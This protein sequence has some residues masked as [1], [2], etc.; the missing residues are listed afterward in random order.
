MQRLI[1]AALVLLAMPIAHGHAE[2]AKEDPDKLFADGNWAEAYD[3]YRDGLHDGGL[4]DSTAAGYVPKA[5]QCL[6]K[7]NRLAEWDAMIKQA[8]EANATK[9]RTLGAAAAAYYSVDHHGRLTDGEFVRGQPR[10]GGWQ[11]MVTADRRDRVRALQLY[12]QSLDVAEAAGDGD[13]AARFL[14][15]MADALQR[16]AASGRYAWRLQLLTDLSKD[17]PLPDTDPGWSPNYGAGSS[18]PV[19]AAGNPLLHNEPASWDDAKTDGERWRWLLAAAVRRDGRLKAEV[20]DRRADFA[21]NQFGVRTLAGLL[22]RLSGAKDDADAGVFAL[23]TLTDNECL[24]RL[25]T[26]VKRFELPAEHHPVRLRQEL[27]AVAIEADDKSAARGA[28]SKLADTMLNRR[29]FKRAAGYFRQSLELTGNEKQR[30][31]IEQRIAQIEGAWGEFQSAP[32]QPAGRGATIDY[33]YRNS[34]AVE[35]VAAPIDI[36]KLLADVKAYLK[37][38]PKQLNR[39]KIEIENLGRRLLYYDR[40]KYVGEPAA[41]WSVKLDPPEDHSDGQLAITTPLQKP[42]AYFV[43]ATPKLADGTP[44]VRH[45]CVLWVADTVLLR[46]PMSGAA[47]FFAADAVTGQPVG[48]ANIELFSYRQV[49]SNEN[50]R[51]YDLSTSSQAIK[52]DAAGLAVLSL[53]DPDEE[54][55]R[56]W[57]AI[58]RDETGRLAYLGFDRIWAGRLD[59]TRPRDSRAFV[60]TDRPVYRPGQKVQFAAWVQ[61]ADYAMAAD[62]ASEFAHKAFRVAL[63]DAKNEKVFAKTLT[64]GAYGNLIG[65]HALPEGAPLGIWRLEV[66]G[67]G[68]GTF[69]VEEYKKPE[70]EVTVTAPDEA[71]LLGQPFTATIEA[72]YYFGSPVTGGTVSYKVTRSPRTDRWWPVQPWD[73]LYGPGYG[74]RPF[75]YSG[76]VP[77]WQAGGGSPE[78]VAEGE[79]PLDGDGVYEV[80]IDTALAK[81]LHGDTDHQYQITAEV[82]DGSRRT[83]TGAGTVTVARE[84]LNVHVWLDRGHYRVEDVVTARVAAR[85]P[86]GSPAV[87]DSWPRLGKLRLLKQSAEVKGEREE[88]PAGR[89]EETEVRQWEVALD[90]RGEAELKI[91]ASEAG[92]YRVVFEL[93]RPESSPGP[94][95]MASTPLAITGPGLESSGFVY[96]DLTLEPDQREYQPTD[97]AKLLLGATRTGATVLLFERPRDGV[98]LKPRL[99]TLQGG[100]KTVDLK[101]TAADSPNVFVEAVSISEGR[102]QSVVRQLAVPPASRVLNVEVLP[103]A[104]AYRPGQEATMKVRLTDQSGEPF[105]G[106]LVLA[107]YDRS[108]DAIAGGSNVPDIRKHFWSW[109]RSHWTR[110]ENNV[111]RPAYNLPA[112][113]KPGMQQLGQFGGVMLGVPVRRG[114]FGG[115]GNDMFFAAPAAAPLAAAPME[116]EAEDMAF[117]AVPADGVDAFASTES[118]LSAQLLAPSI[119]TEFADTAFWTASLETDADGLAEVTFPMPENLTAWQI[120]VWGMGHGCRVGQGESEVVTR[121]DLLVRLQTPRFLVERDEVV[122]SANV[123]NYLDADKEVQVRLELDGEQLEAPTDAQQTITVPAGED[124]RVDWRLRALAEGEA[125][126]RALAL[127]DEESDAMQLPLPV[128]VHGALVM[129]PFSGVIDRADRLAT[130]EFTVP[131]QRRPEQTRLEVRYSPTLAGAMLDALPYLIDYPHGCT[132]QTLNRFLPAVLTR[133]T[134]Q[135]MG[136]SLDE[137]KDAAAKLD[138]TRAGG[139]EDPTKDAWRRRQDNPVFDKEKLDAIVAEG[140]RR[141]TD[142]QLSD[143]GWGWFSGFGERSTPHTTAVVVRGLLEA[144]DADLAIVPGVIDR[145]VAWLAGHQQRE[146][147][148]LNSYDDAGN[149][150]DDA[151]RSKRYAD[152]LDALVLLA[153]TQAG[154]PNAEMRDRLLAARTRLSPYGLSLLG[155]ALAEEDGQDEKLAAVMRNLRQY[156][157]SDEEIQTTFLNLPGSGWWFWHGSHTETHAAYLKLLA[158]ADPDSAATAGLVK[159]LLTARRHATYWDSTRDTALVIEAMADY[160]QATGEGRA[161]LN[162]EVW[163]D[164]GR[165]KQ[166]TI[167]PENL[168]GFDN[169]LTI[170]GAALTPG[171]HTLEL[172]KTGPGRLYWNAALTNFSLEDD[173]KAT[174]LDLR[175]RRRL[176][177]L[178]PEPTEEAAAS[179]TGQAVTQRGEKMTRTEVTNLASVESGDLVE[180]ELT[181]TSKNDY[182][183]L[184]LTD[185]KAAGF[186][187]VEVRS[188]YNGNQLGAYVEYRDRAV[189]LF[190]RRL[191]RGERSVSY[192]LRAVTPGAFSAL[193]ATAAAMYAPELRGTSDEIKV[194]VKDAEPEATS[195]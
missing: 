162:V 20:L 57:L 171:A 76:F 55:R 188:G 132:E 82:T 179:A 101:L 114:G 185:E 129:E 62:D 102:V 96:R 131:E 164:G 109:T 65:E 118:A 41:D 117:G 133:K 100:A 187:P 182:E 145:G 127:T 161:E 153:T 46:K 192:R 38:Q 160:L 193:P 186:E 123:H 135:R 50:P 25:A 2:E 35:L 26:G 120:K 88:S 56:Q 115:G 93:P 172:R 174:G 66:E 14:I 148:A 63:Y 177:K 113:G 70:F 37:E 103:S 166:V 61:R 9:W 191:P 33:R 11:G 59:P 51:Q 47:L 121:K 81:A 144:R 156:Q 78:V 90:A 17:A 178:T 71:V 98:Y 159:H 184:I 181:V 28:A 167:S 95:V 147:A 34:A 136:V 165:R 16:R 169:R 7:L 128:A 105:T 139:D 69:R 15:H 30:K 53:G 163:V 84:P 143:G 146:L 21:A 43:S 80:T 48:G 8:V 23:S 75:A 124:R 91:K 155:L 31:G 64:A 6:A 195:P 49:R 119:R 86:D 106:E 45:H 173:L 83:I 104:E 42:G 54:R 154:K 122:L 5:T 19:D 92:H 137:V 152:N 79:A 44:G 12:R 151:K 10:R 4:E 149:R 176:Y 22:P 170:D 73:W 168:L 52:T 116:E 24:A 190:V 141:L 130:F 112:R 107:V 126:V 39:N 99:V 97:T 140:L 60:M 157:Q 134:L 40:K 189:N 1:L 74:L 138:A 150:I 175:I 142:M 180:V 32:T 85:K 68:Q 108:L 27:L 18:A 29:Q 87:G 125:T 67:Q 13:T 183:Y 77:R 89:Q 58:A 158:A 72:R 36:A 110:G 3:L 194:V 94:D 111:S